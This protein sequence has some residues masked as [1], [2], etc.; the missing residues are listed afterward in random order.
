MADRYDDRYRNEDYRRERG[1][2]G[3]DFGRDDRGFFDRASDEVRSWFGDDEAERR[4]H[5]DEARY[6]R[7][8]DRYGRNTERYGSDRDR[9]ERYGRDWDY[10]HRM[11][12]DYGRG[13]RGD[14]R[15]R[16][17]Y[18][19][20]SYAQRGADYSPVDY[21]RPGWPASWNEPRYDY[22]DRARSDSYSGGGYAS[23][24]RSG[25]SG[26]FTGRGPR[27]YQRSDDRI[28]EDVCDRLAE[29]PWIDAGDIEVS[30]RSGEVTLSGSVRD[31][32]D[33]H[34]AEDMIENVSGVRDVHNQLRV[35]SGWGK[36]SAGAREQQQPMSTPTTAAQTPTRR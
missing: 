25:R 4:R 23:G 11:G 3:R 31:R 33:K 22:G 14:W 10:G 24:E 17:S 16:T 6:G 13:P 27:G 12:F 2:G 30:V 8:W 1:Y 32:S 35:G 36:E 5:M 18:P 28:R 19:Q 29:D 20:R 7:D 26:S 34:R 9:D 21:W 15:D